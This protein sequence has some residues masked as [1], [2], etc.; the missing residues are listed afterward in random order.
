MSYEA[1]SAHCHEHAHRPEDC[2][3]YVPKMKFAGFGRA[4]IPRQ[5]LCELFSGK[6]GF[7]AGTIFPELY[8]PYEGRVSTQNLECEE[9]DDFA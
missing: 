3:N 4:Y 9:G 6:E 2:S 8:M 5:R 1:E 7:V